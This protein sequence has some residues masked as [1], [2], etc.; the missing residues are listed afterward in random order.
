MKN[1]YLMDFL[2][3][4]IGEIVRDARGPNRKISD[5]LAIKTILALITAPRAQTALE[6]A[7][8]TALAFVMRAVNR[9]LLSNSKTPRALLKELM[10]ILS[11]CSSMVPAHRLGNVW[12]KKRLDS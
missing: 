10:E 2:F 1:E 9:V 6:H 12:P 7:N 3:K 5:E 11:D 4:K 8:D